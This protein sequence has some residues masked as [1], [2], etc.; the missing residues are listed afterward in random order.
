MS[1]GRLGPVDTVVYADMSCPVA[2]RAQD[3]ENCRS[4]RQCGYHFFDGGKHDVEARQRLCQIAVSFVGDD[5]R[6]PC[7]GDQK[8]GSRQ[9]CV[10]FKETSPKDGAGLGNKVGGSVS[11]KRFGLVAVMMLAKQFDH[12]R[13]GLVN[14]WGNDVTRDF[15]GELDDVFAEVRLDDLY[16]LLLQIRIEADFLSHHSLALAQYPDAASS[17]Q[18]PY[19]PARV[20]RRF[21]PVDNPSLFPTA[22]LECLQVLVEVAKSP[23]LGPHRSVSSVLEAREPL[24]GVGSAGLE[25]PTE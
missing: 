14:C 4:F 3:P 24:D 7:F 20:F 10:G 1:D 22:R 23:S 18:L 15:L 16:A 21:S 5:D 25:P 8:V 2:E 11:R 9:A 19:N 13:H 12:L 17:Q 6:A